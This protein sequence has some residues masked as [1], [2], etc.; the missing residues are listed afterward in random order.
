MGVRKRLLALAAVLSTA[1]TSPPARA[2]GFDGARAIETFDAAWRLIRDTHFDPAF[3]GLDWNDVGARYRER[4]AAATDEAQ[5]REIIDEMLSELGQSHFGLIRGSRPGG[6]V[7]G[8][9]TSAGGAGPEALWDLLHAP[10]GDAGPGFDTRVLDGRVVVF[11]VDPEGPADR[12]GV[13]PGWVVEAIEGR[14]LAEQVSWIEEEIGKGIAILAWR[15]VG[16]QLSG[17]TGTT[18]RLDFLDG[19]DMPRSLVIPRAAKRGALVQFGNLPPLHSRFALSWNEPPGT[20]LRIAHVAFNIWLF[21]VAAAFDSVYSAVQDADGIIVDLRGNVGG[22]GGLAPGLA[23]YF[24]GERKSLG[25]MVNRGQEVPFA[26]IPRRVTQDGEPIAPFDGPLAILIDGLSAS[27]S[28]IFASGM[29]DLERARIFGMPSAGAALP[30]L[31]DTLPNGDV[32]MHAVAD[33]VTPG[34]HR[35]EGHPAVPDEPIVLKRD[36][37]L[38][39]RDVALE[40]AERWIAR[41]V[42]RGA[43]AGR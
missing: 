3:G 30:A 38:A 24:L 16:A 25:T 15:L 35:L 37:L 39:G 21:P 10:V 12:A 5:L 11:T 26:I 43:T 42:G 22:I 1:L 32:L 31:A 23:G 40:S 9:D 17:A 20:D 14:P 4:A 19:Y 7:A 34:G 27:T 28:E 2:N 18:V 41:E 13:R 36:D 8:A 6:S 29:R 33:F